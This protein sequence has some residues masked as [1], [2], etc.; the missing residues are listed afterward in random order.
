MPS[1]KLRDFQVGHD[2]VFANPES[3]LVAGRIAAS[4]LAV[5]LLVTVW[6]FARAL[7]GQS[8]ATAQQVLLFDPQNGMAHAVLCYAYATT[9][10][11]G[12]AE[13]HCNLALKLIQ[14]DPYGLE[15]DSR[16][17]RAFMGKHGLQL[18]TDV[19]R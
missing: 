3:V 12:T 14:Q 10:D 15:T 6:L 17:V 16:T 5:L 18:S 9:G 13:Q 4:I 1:N 2:F 7:F 19:A 11:R 8:V